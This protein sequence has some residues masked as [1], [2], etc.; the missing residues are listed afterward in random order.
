MTI[1]PRS[2]SQLEKDLVDEPQRLRG[3]GLGCACCGGKDDSQQRSPLEPQPEAAQAQTREEQA[4]K[5]P[6]KQHIPRVSEPTPKPRPQAEALEESFAAKQSAETALTTPGKAE[7]GNASLSSNVPSTAVSR[8]PS[9]T[10]GQEGH[11]DPGDSSSRLV[12]TRDPLAEEY[13]S[14]QPGTGQD[15]PLSE[16][17]T[18]KKGQLP[19]PSGPASTLK[20]RTGLN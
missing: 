12:G 8:T 14:P 17:S 4:S 6:A 15:I 11:E 10:A 1:R 5:P 18:D 19:P 7:P 20:D 2:N 9:A 13:H 3:G 16:L